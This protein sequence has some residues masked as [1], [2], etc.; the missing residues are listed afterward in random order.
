MCDKFSLL[1]FEC[2]DSPGG[3]RAER[4][5]IDHLGHNKAAASGSNPNL[6]LYEMGIFYE[7]LTVLEAHQKHEKGLNSNI[8]TFPGVCRTLNISA[9]LI[10]HLPSNNTLS[11]TSFMDLLCFPLAKK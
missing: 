7:I 10:K 9:S 1:D 3:E 5:G 6:S 8:T 4:E 11:G 2:T